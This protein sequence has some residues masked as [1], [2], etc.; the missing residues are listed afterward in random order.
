MNKDNILNYK[1]C[2]NNLKYCVN[3]YE[4]ILNF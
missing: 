1:I 3:K 4:N 2:I